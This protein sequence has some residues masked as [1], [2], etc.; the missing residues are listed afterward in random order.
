MYV[1]ADPCPAAL[2]AL[3][4]VVGPHA[5]QVAS[6][7]EMYGASGVVDAPRQRATFAAAR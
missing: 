4:R 1:A 6:I 5:L 2:A 7:A 3:A